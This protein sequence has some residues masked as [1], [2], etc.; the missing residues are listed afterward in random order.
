M[1][2]QKTIKNI[3]DAIVDYIFDNATFESNDAIKDCIKQIERLRSFNEIFRIPIENRLFNFDS[4]LHWLYF[5]CFLINVINDEQ[6]V[7]PQS[8]STTFNS[9]DAIIYISNRYDN[10]NEEMYDDYFKKSIS[11]SDS[12]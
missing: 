9:N 11:D 1:P 8:F 2:V 6:I 3:H 10:I 4:S 7:V 5:I 12:D